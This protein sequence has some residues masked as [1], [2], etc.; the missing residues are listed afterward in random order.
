MCLDDAPNH[1]E[2]LGAKAMTASQPDRIEPEL[3]GL[4]LT[5]DV[6]MGWLIRPNVTIKPFFTQRISISS[7]RLTVPRATPPGTYFLGFFI[8]DPKDRV[9][10]NNSSWSTSGVTVVVLP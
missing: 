5:L 3:A 1:V 8:R 10:S 2:L 4:V 7:V 6:Y 9:Q